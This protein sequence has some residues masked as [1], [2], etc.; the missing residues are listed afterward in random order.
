MEGKMKLSTADIKE[1]IQE[2][3]ADKEVHSVPELR[4]YII[5]MKGDTFT[6]GQLSGSIFQLADRGI[7]KSVARG[8][9]V[10]NSPEKEVCEQKEEVVSYQE[11]SLF[12]REIQEC[13]EE[14]NNKIQAIANRPD[15]LELTE[16]D[17][18]YLGEIKRLSS[19]IKELMK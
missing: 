15:V 17:F 10:I 11:K 5:R 2:C 13:L 9:Y 16:K 4:E 12:R 1:L 6:T 7:I 8:K 19:L 3:M 18:K 14:A